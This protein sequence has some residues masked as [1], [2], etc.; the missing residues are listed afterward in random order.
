MDSRNPRANTLL[1][2]IVKSNTI[3]NLVWEMNNT[4]NSNWQEA[5]LT[6]YFFIP[7]IQIMFVGS[8]LS[9][10][11]RDI[12]I[13]DIR[14]INN[15]VCEDSPIFTTITTKSSTSTTKVTYP[16]TTT[17]TTAT[18]TTSTTTTTNTASTTNYL[19]DFDCDFESTCNWKNTNSSKFN[20][21]KTYKINELRKD[22][23]QNDAFAP[24][25][26]HTLGTDE[27][28]I[29][30]LSDRQSFYRQEKVGYISPVINDTK[31][32]EFYYYLYGDEVGELNVYKKRVDTN[33][34]NRIWSTKQSSEAGWRFAQASSYF[35]DYTLKYQLLFGVLLRGQ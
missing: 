23:I 12:A 21:W 16:S 7:D 19:Q 26:D 6:L 4:Q 29:L 18:R 25:L 32:V 2:V 35:I 28:S 27:G 11:R 30:S 22:N 33:T 10:E 24:L 17:T 8:K 1:Q 20:T 31:C 3:D 9:N 15:Q 5:R 14:V 34:P 13:D